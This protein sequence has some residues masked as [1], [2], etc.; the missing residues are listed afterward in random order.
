MEVLRLTGCRLEE[1]LEISHHSLI[2]YRLPVTGEIVPLLQIIPSK[3]DQER[4]LPID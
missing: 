1:L 2:Q 3:T 4:L